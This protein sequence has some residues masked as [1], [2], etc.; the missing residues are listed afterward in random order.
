MRNNTMGAGGW[1]SRSWFTGL[2]LPGESMVHLLISA[3]LEND[4]HVGN[5]IGW[6]A[7]LYGGFL[8]YN[9]ADDGSKEMWWSTFCVVGKVL[10]R[11]GGGR[12]CMGWISIG[13]GVCVLAGNDRDEDLAGGE[14]VEG[15]VAVR[16]KQVVDE[17]MDENMGLVERVDKP[18][19][20][21]R[22]SCILGRGWREGMEVLESDFVVPIP[23][24]GAVQV[25]IELEGL[26]FRRCLPEVFVGEDGYEEEY[27]ED[28]PATNYDVAAAFLVMENR[29]GD[30][31][32]VMGVEMAYRRPSEVVARRKRRVVFQLAYDVMFVTA[33]PCSAPEEEEDGSDDPD[34]P[35]CHLLHKSHA[36]TIH[37]LV[38][39]PGLSGPSLQQ[40]LL[41]PLGSFTFNTTSAEGDAGPR[42]PSRKPSVMVINAKGA[43][44]QGE[45]FAK[46]WCAD[47]GVRGVVLAREGRGCLGCA[48]R[49]AAG[50]GVG[51]VV[52]MGREEVEW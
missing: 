26:V 11:I 27:D 32:G 12:E 36:Y 44:A 28:A 47:R 30:D 29:E 6:E 20:V 13:K 7:E 4:K 1:L 25:G 46:A 2:V 39:L 24:E 8:L 51:V 49:E 3:L 9:G 23:D 18:R 40:S 52:W 45:A 48:V 14:D 19:E 41:Q 42:S 22:M 16:T 33:F 43:G 35:H 31:A 34:V 21:A 50:L 17:E 38:S 5:R 15:W 10:G 37:Q